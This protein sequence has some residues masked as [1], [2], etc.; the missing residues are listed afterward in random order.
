MNSLSNIGFKDI[1]I[2]CLIAFVGWTQFQQHQA[3]GPL[4]GT[5]AHQIATGVAQ[6]KTQLVSSIDTEKL[7]KAIADAVATQMVKARADI[8]SE[9]KGA[10]SSRSN[11]HSVNVDKYKT[12]KKTLQWEADDGQV[13]PIGVAIYSPKKDE[14][15]KDPWIA[16]AYNLKFKTQVV[17][18]IDRDG[19][20][21]NTVA[22]SAQPK[23]LKGYTGVD[24]PI[25]VNLNET[26]FTEV[27]EKKYEWALWNPTLSLGLN[28][29]W[30]STNGVDYG[31]LGKFNF[32][33]Y[34]YASQLPV[35]QLASPVVIMNGNTVDI[36]LEIVSY[37][38]GEALPVIKDLHL[39]VGI[40]WNKLPFLS[41]TSVF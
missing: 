13:M 4:H 3:T 24:F 7:N 36:G 11:E 34:G 18:S 41:L 8:I 31:F 2:I 25:K 35:W 15:G 32:I 29:R 26:L 33:N 27:Q 1:L 21:H 23:N 22:L 16:K 39:G 5:E 30:D 20:V 37:N 19:G 12:K 40:E 10:W 9:V 17:R 6:G 28:T 14:A 38:L